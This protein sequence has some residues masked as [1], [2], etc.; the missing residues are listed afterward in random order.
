MIGKIAL[1][2]GSFNEQTIKDRNK[3]LSE[4]NRDDGDEFVHID[5]ATYDTSRTV[6][7]HGEIDQLSEDTLS[8]YLENRKRSGGGRIERLDMSSSPAT[9]T[10]EEVAGK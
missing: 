5:S 2:V 9:V 4:K 6:E 3:K 8:L 1:N 10:F 7:I